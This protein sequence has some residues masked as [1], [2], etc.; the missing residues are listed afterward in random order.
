M[1][2]TERGQ[3]R[4]AFRLWDTVSLLKQAH[5]FSTFSSSALYLM[6][7]KSQEE[8]YASGSQIVGVDNKLPGGVHFMLEGEAHFCTVPTGGSSRNT[9]MHVG[10]LSITG[11]VGGMLGTVESVVETN[12]KESEKDIL[13]SGAIVKLESGVKKRGVTTI[14]SRP[15]VFNKVHSSKRGTI[16]KVRGGGGEGGSDGGKRR[17]QGRERG[18][19]CELG[20]C[21]VEGWREGREEGATTPYTLL[22]GNN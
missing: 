22:H 8:V 20:G 16:L 3:G 18:E 6:A 10:P 13:R 5:I 19:G 17:G 2:Q 15:N 11:D 7:M 1:G 21:E 9:I 4:T 12:K 14:R